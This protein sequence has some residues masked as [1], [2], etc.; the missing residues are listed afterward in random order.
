MFKWLVKVKGQTNNYVLTVLTDSKITASGSRSLQLYHIELHMVGIISQIIK[1]W[2]M[3]LK[4]PACSHEATCLIAD[5]HYYIY[6]STDGNISL[7]HSRKRTMLCAS[8]LLK[9]VHDNLC[10]HDVSPLTSHLR[11]QTTFLR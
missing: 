5:V 11:R 4:N 10:S 8:L 6:S 9:I 1:R 3:A 7:F 2:D